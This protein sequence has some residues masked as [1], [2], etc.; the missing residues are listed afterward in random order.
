M[1]NSFYS[2]QK[3]EF[4]QVEEEVYHFLAI[5]YEHIEEYAVFVFGKLAGDKGGVTNF[6]LFGVSDKSLSCTIGVGEKYLLVPNQ[7]FA[8]SNSLDAL[9]LTVGI[10]QHPQDVLLDDVC[11]TLLKITERKSKHFLNQRNNDEAYI[12]QEQEVLFTMHTI[13]RV[14][15]IKQTVENSRLWEVELAI[16]DENDPQFSART[17]LIKDEIGGEG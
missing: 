9:F 3:V 1:G 14:G 11:K 4:Q 7:I 17:S 6:L 10:N 2:S 8:R 12:P 16:N 5:H 13:F 15:E